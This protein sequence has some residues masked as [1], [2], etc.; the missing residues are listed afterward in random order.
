[1]KKKKLSKKVEDSDSIAKYIE[2]QFINTPQE[3]DSFK[4]TKETIAPL[5]TPKKQYFA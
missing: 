4:K 5:T 2:K 1:M 3:I